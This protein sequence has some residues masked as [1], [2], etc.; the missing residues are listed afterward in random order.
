[1]SWIVLNDPSVSEEIT[2]IRAAPCRRA[3]A[4]PA[5]WDWDK[6]TDRTL[7]A[8]DLETG[9]LTGFHD[10]LPV[11]T[12]CAGQAFL[13]DGRLLAA[14]GRIPGG[15]TFNDH[16][17]HPHHEPGN[18]DVGCTAEAQWWMKPLKLHFQPGSKRQAAAVG[19]DVGHA[20]F[21][22]GLRGSRHPAADDLGAMMIQP[23]NVSL[24]KPS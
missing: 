7:L 11:P 6:F 4:S 13:A 21:R 16:P 8:S 18:M 10:S 24:F 9:A 22:R 5:F 20:R 12:S 1:M 23:I 2:A 14:G 15:E 17:I 19:T 3:A